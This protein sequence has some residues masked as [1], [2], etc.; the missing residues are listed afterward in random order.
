MHPPPTWT[1]LAR[2]SVAH[3]RWRTHRL[4]LALSARLADPGLWAS[5]TCRVH[6]GGDV[7]RPAIVVT[8]ADPP[9]DGVLDAGRARLLVQFDDGVAPATWCLAGADVAWRLHRHSAEVTDEAGTRVLAAPCHLPAPV[10]ARPMP[11]PLPDDA[12]PQGGAGTR[13]AGRDAAAADGRR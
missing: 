13:G 8:D 6:V 1:S 3:R 4:V 2:P 10:L 7:P 11:W 12:D 5:G 9:V